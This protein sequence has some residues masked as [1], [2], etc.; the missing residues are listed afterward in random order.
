MWD[1]NKFSASSV[2]LRGLGDA[3]WAVAFNLDGRCTC[4]PRMWREIRGQAR[5]IDKQETGLSQDQSLIW[6]S[7]QE[8]LTVDMMQ[9]VLLLSNLSLGR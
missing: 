7:R 5:I 8:P 6:E 4:L 2:V 9:N 1:T 3:V